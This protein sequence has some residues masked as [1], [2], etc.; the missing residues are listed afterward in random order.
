MVLIA[1]FFLSYMSI[2]RIAILLSSSPQC[3]LTFLPI[4][5][6]YHLCA[7]FQIP[8]H[9]ANAAAFSTAHPLPL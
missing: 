9:P 2:F 1:F 8:L 5:P 6:S 7:Q 3:P 4:P